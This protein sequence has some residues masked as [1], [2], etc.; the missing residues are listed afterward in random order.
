VREP[1][2]VILITRGEKTENL[3]LLKPAKHVEKKDITITKYTYSI[4]SKL[5]NGI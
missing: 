5:I 3:D 2:E 1:L 4:P